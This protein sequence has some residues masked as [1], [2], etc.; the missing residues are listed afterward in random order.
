MKQTTYT[1]HINNIERREAL[2][3]FMDLGLV[4]IAGSLGLSYVW[5]NH[6]D[7]SAIESSLANN[8]VI[9]HSIHAESVPYFIAYPYTTLLLSSSLIYNP[10]YLFTL[11]KLN[12][13]FIILLDSLHTPLLETLQNIKANLEYINQKYI[14]NNLES[15]LDSIIQS[16]Q[17]SD[18]LLYIHNQTLS[19]KSIGAYIKNEDV[20]QK[21]FKDVIRNNLYTYN[22]SYFDNAQENESTQIY[23]EA[24]IKVHSYIDNI[25]SQN[26]HTTQ[27]TQ[28][29]FQNLIN[30]KLTQTKLKYQN[31]QNNIAYQQVG[32]TTNSQRDFIIQLKRV[33]EYSYRVYKGERVLNS[34]PI[35]TAKTKD[36]VNETILS[37]FVYNETFIP[38]K[39]DIHKEL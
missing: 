18:A 39:I 33:A 37:N 28:T 19:Y 1:L 8:E 15:K 12:T 13:S 16:L 24:H 5:N 38:T 26:T 20:A 10:S 30:K 27:Q 36:S 21:H 3:T 14:S 22:S 7:S 4:S 32:E 25:Q 35:M 23:K 11:L 29:N 34:D 31:P 2:K 6:K 9:K 17:H